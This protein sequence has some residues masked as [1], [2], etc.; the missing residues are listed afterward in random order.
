MFLVED[1]FSFFWDGCLS[2]DE[3]HVMEYF[4]SIHGYKCCS[5]SP[6]F[7]DCSAWISVLTFVVYLANLLK[8]QT[9]SKKKATHLRMNQINPATIKQ[10]L[11]VSG[12]LLCWFAVVVIK[13]KGCTL[14]FRNSFFFSPYSDPFCW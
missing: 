9:Y 8:V 1:Y 13:M 11:F 7:F 2:I 14:C 12:V 10:N 4:C 5:F 3:F 6:L